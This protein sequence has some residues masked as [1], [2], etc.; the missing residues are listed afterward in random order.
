[1]IDY[2]NTVPYVNYNQPVDFIFIP[3]HSQIYSNPWNCNSPKLLEGIAQTTTFIREMV[4]LVGVTPY[5]RIILP[6]A[7]IRSNLEKEVFTAE[8]MEEMKNSVIILGIEN[9]LKSTVEGMTYTIDVP[10]PTRYHTMQKWTAKESSSTDETEDY[11]L[12]QDRPYLL[13]SSYCPLSASILISSRLP[14]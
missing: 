11:F 6:I 10:Y 13:V 4:R 14:D 8:F 1:M 2:P 7:T 5:P 9:A 3:I 12:N